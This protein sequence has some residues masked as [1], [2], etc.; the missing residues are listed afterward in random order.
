M[1]HETPFTMSK[2]HRTET[3]PHAILFGNNRKKLIFVGNV[4]P[5][6]AKRKAA[7]VAATVEA[8]DIPMPDAPPETVYDKNP[9]SRMSGVTVE[10]YNI[11]D[12]ST[13][14][15]ETK[16]SW[17]YDMGSGNGHP[18]DSVTVITI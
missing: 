5:L 13:G 3:H 6:T 7:I 17:T 14:S 11:T 10:W 8:F 1:T 15:T 4:Y 12:N 18:A 2:P 9:Y 16:V